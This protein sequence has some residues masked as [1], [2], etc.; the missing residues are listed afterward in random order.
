MPPLRHTRVRCCGSET[1]GWA[2]V[3]HT[4]AACNARARSAQVGVSA[5]TTANP[6]K[7]FLEMLRFSDGDPRHAQEWIG[8]SAVR[9]KQLQAL[10]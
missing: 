10:F 7:S 1:V 6:R 9:D 8:V 3:G 5:G 4:R 2:G